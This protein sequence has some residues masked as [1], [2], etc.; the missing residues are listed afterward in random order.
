MS[1]STTR[2]LVRH[3]RPKTRRADSTSGHYE[4]ATLLG[5]VIVIAVV[6]WIH[7]QHRRQSLAGPGDDKP[8][9]YENPT[10]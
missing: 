10:T 2:A 4:T 9:G 5:A 3:R 7:R 6:A 8:A 1:H